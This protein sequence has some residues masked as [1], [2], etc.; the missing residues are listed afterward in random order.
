M[1]RTGSPDI[2]MPLALFG[3]GLIVVNKIFGEDK[4]DKAAAAANLALET[5]P[6][7]RNPFNVNTYKAAKR[8]DASRYVTKASSL[9]A[10]AVRIHKAIGIF[11]DDESAIMDGI[12]T[13]RTRFEV[14]LIA[15]IFSKEY[16]EDL[17]A[18]LKSN[19]NEK[20]IATVNSYVLQLPT[21]FK[22]PGKSN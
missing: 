2:A 13:A 11:T 22:T 4:E 14:Y 16:K 8:P 5:L 21:Y 1:A 15:Y 20:E 18:E 10:A 9:H 3:L 12:K 17:Y 6:A 19:L 7:N